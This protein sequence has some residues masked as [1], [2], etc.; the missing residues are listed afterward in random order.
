MGLEWTS[1]VSKNY[2]ILEFW[3]NYPFKNNS[4]SLW[5]LRT[6]NHI[7]KHWVKGLNIKWRWER[8]CGVTAPS[9]II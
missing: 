1:R 8:F 9:F 6:E 4:Y 5:V 3:V 7:P 2:I